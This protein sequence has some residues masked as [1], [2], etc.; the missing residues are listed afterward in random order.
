MNQ[1]LMA[2]RFLRRDWRSGELRLLSLALVVAVAAVTTVSFFTDRVERAMT[3]QAAEILAADLVLSS[4]NP[5]PPEFAQ[6]ALQLGLQ[7]AATLSFPSVVL[8]GDETQLVEVKAVDPRYPLRG[9]LRTRPQPGAAEEITPETPRPGELWAEPRLLAVLDIQP[10]GEIALGEMTFRVNRVLSRDSGEGSSFLRLGPKVLMALEDI[11]ATGLVGPAS[12]VRHQLLVAG[13]EGAVKRF[14]DWSGPRLPT[15]VRLEQMSSARP[16]LRNALDR[17]GRFLGLAALAAVLV[18]GAAVALSTRR[19]VERQSDTSAIMRCLGASSRVILQ[20][21]LLRLLMLGLMASLTGALAGYLAQFFLANLLQGQFGSELPLPGLWPIVVG[22]ATGLVTL[23]GFTLPPA[24]RLAAVPPLRVLR[25]ELGAA[26]PAAWMV[27]L[28]SV[29]AI[30]LLMLWQAG[31]PALAGWVLLGTLLTSGL[32]LLTAWGLVRLLAPLRRQGGALWRYGLAGLVR[33]PGMTALQLTGF[34]LGILAMLLLAIVRLDLMAAWQQT[35]PDDAPN[36][37]LIN[38]QPDEV[39]SLNRFLTDSGIEEHT[40]YPMLRA[41]LVRINAR[42]VS[43]DDYRDGRAQ[44]LISREFNLSHGQ[45]MPLGNQILAGE[46]WGAEAQQSDLFSVEIGIA[47]TLGIQLG[48]RLTFNLAGSEIAGNVTS[49][50]RVKWD[51]F[52]PNFFVIGSPALLQPHPANFITSFHLPSGRERLLADLVSRFPA[53]TIIDVTS[54]MQQIREVIA[55]GSLAVQYVFFFTL[56]AGLLMLYAG[57]QASR[58]HRRQ[59]SAI[60]R[61]LGM[62]R[63][64][65]LTAA[66]VE[67]STLGLLAGLLASGCASLTG[68]LLAS[69]VF[70]FPFHFNPWLWVAGIVGSSLIIGLAGVIASYPLTIHPPLRTLQES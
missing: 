31:D 40:L 11:P 51:S 60:L 61:T 57:I 62:K 27:A 54:L 13:S 30:A 29:A 23:T 5:L 20:V 25:R 46:W 9:E 10:G 49:L 58:D 67:F 44:R 24:V 63:R 65:L 35:I 8:K 48:D 68:W 42:A 69:E 14:S 52:Q 21:L 43:A 1:P 56:G 53:V 38:I 64:G 7:T 2:L 3:H 47:E 12:R 70:G 59:E 36:Q 39:A 22:L 45:Q 15:G 55:R 37:F 19:F 32:L 6:Q 28:F 16:A 50:R 4:N 34:G 41:R 18:A 17:A 66:W 26:P 33:N